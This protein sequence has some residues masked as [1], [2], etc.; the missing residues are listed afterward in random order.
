MTNTPSGDK[1]KDKDDGRDTVEEVQDSAMSR[2]LDRQG[3]KV[4]LS[5]PPPWIVHVSFLEDGEEIPV[6]WPFQDEKSARM[7]YALAVKS[8][9]FVRVLRKATKKRPAFTVTLV[10]LWHVMFGE[11]IHG[12]P[13]I[14]YRGVP[15][16]E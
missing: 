9:Q 1:D 5:D 14:W 3:I 4:D 10:S 7:A 13:S 16:P 8:G 2:W 12:K 11:D 6:T 15:V